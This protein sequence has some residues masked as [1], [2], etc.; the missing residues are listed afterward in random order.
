MLGPRVGL[1]PQRHNFTLRIP[2]CW[3]LNFALPPTRKLKFA[4]PQRKQVEYRWRW[5]PN[6]RGWRWLCR[7]HVV[8]LIFGRVGYPTQTRYPVK[9]RLYSYTSVRSRDCPSLFQTPGVK[10]EMKHF[11]LIVISEQDVLYLSTILPKVKD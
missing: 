8:C 9:Y 7:F 3:Y 6:A 1:D 4:N 5:V 2:I 11:L 10:S